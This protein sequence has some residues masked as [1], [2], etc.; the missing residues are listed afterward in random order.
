MLPAN[1]H[2]DSRNLTH[3]RVQRAHPST[4]AL[5]AATQTKVG[6]ESVATVRRNIALTEAAIRSGKLSADKR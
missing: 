1:N 2:G 3:Q 5:E 6:P 4:D